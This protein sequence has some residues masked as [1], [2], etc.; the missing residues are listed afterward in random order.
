MIFVNGDPDIHFQGQMIRYF[1]AGRDAMTLVEM[2]LKLV[3]G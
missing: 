1:I 2:L 3:Q